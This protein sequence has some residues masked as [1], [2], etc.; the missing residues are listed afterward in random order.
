MFPDMDDIDVLAGV[1]D[2][3]GGLIAGTTREQ[4]SASTPCP[5]FDVQTLVGHI[6]GWVR[7]FDVAANGGTFDGDPSSYDVHEGSA[8]DFRSHAASMLEGWRAHGVDRTVNLVGGEM[9]AP[10]VFNMAF[11]EYM[12][13][14]WDLARGTGQAVPF[15]DE[16]ATETLRRGRETLQP[17]FRGGQIG[18]EITLPAESPAIDQFVAFMGRQP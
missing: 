8:A 12:A 18:P 4:W 7:V 15:T 9:P 14:G 3:T 13:H 1:L 11:M 10:M 2:K 6:V 5:E 17:Q 16:E